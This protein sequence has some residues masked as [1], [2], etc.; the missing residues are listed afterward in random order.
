[1]GLKVQWYTSG[2]QK[3]YIIHKRSPV[4]LWLWSC[5]A[6]FGDESA[7]ISTKWFSNSSDPLV[8]PPLQVNSS[9]TE[10]GN[11]EGTQRNRWQSTFLAC[12]SRVNPFQLILYFKPQRNGVRVYSGD[13]GWFIYKWPCD[14]HLPPQT[15]S[16]P[17]WK[18]LRWIHFYKQGS[19]LCTAQTQS[20]RGIILAAPVWIF[21]FSP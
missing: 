2:I 11:H 18:T 13:V 3:A 10:K 19:R 8:K 20:A 1:M 7:V 4:L 9:Y 21:Q 5:S 14:S 15:D 16:S 6:V 12:A 17:T